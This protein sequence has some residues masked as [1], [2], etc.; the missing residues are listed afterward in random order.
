MIPLHPEFLRHQQ[1]VPQHLPFTKK[2]PG[3]GMDQ[4]TQRSLGSGGMGGMANWEVFVS[5]LEL[6]DSFPPKIVG[7]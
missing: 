1:A 5:P 2:T 4:S 6:G 7:F 3:G